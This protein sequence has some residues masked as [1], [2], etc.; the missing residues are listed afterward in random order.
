M[1]RNWDRFYV[2]MMYCSLIKILD[3]PVRHSSPYDKYYCLIPKWGSDL[4][5]CGMPFRCPI[6]PSQYIHIAGDMLSGSVTFLLPIAWEWIVRV[7]RWSFLIPTDMLPN[8]EHGELQNLSS[9]KAWS[10]HC[11]SSV[12]MHRGI[13]SDKLKQSGQ[14]SLAMKVYHC[15]D[16]KVYSL[17]KV[18]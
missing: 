12:N 18:R 11:S 13:G 5:R 17:Q 10:E 2:D 14:Q 6:C 3:A 15:W 9:V 16:A 8:A 7:N 4:H 1:T